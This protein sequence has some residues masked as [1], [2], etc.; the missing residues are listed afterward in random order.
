MIGTLF[1][2]A[3]QHVFRGGSFDPQSILKGAAACFD[4]YRM[5]KMQNGLTLAQKISNVVEI[6]AKG[7]PAARIIL[8]FMVEVVETAI[9]LWHTAWQTPTTESEVHDDERYECKYCDE[10]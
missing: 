2:T 3:A 4:L 10:P 6:L 1:K 7:V 8:S 9:N 5:C